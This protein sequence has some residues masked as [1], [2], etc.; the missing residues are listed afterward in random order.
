MLSLRL[1]SRRGLWQGPAALLAAAAAL[2]AALA[3]AA[4]ASAAAARQAGAGTGSGSVSI[5]SVSPQVA[6][7][8]GTVSV[9]GT[10]SNGTGHVLSGLQ[11]QLF[12][13]PLW[14]TTRDQMDA[15]LTGGTAAWEQA[16][17]PFVIAGGVAPGATA[18]WHASFKV[19]V[20]GMTQFGVYPLTAKLIGVSGGVLSSD[21][22]LLP[23]WPGKQAAGLAGPLQV[24][25]AWPL[26]DKPRRQV[27]T[28]LTGND[29]APSL[30]PG[31]RLAALLAAG[32]Q[33]PGADLTWVID[34]ALLADADAMTR[35]YQVGSTAN[36]TTGTAKEPASAAAARWLS[37]LRM[38][39]SQQQAVITPY[40][41]ADATALVHQGLTG[42]LG[43][44][45]ALGRVVAGDVLRRPLGY[46]VTA[47]AGGAADLSTLTALAAAEHVGTV[48]LNSS[49]MPP[50]P[51]QG[52]RPDNAVT[53]VRTG[54]G[55]TMSVLL[56]DD[57]LTRILAAGG[58]AAAAQGTQFA[59]EQRF[60]AE[61]AM[62]AAEAPASARAVVVAPPD[63]WSPTAALASA[64]LS[65][66]VSAP[67]LKPTTL[68]SL[69]GDG[70]D[71]TI[72]A[73]LPVSKQSPGELSGGY[74]S[75]VRA[76]GAS[77]SLYES[78]LYEAPAPYRQALDEALAATESS[79]WRGGAR[80]QG[81]ALA[82]GL[83]DYLA[84]AESKVKI[85]ASAQVTMGGASGT[86][87]V[88]IENGL[89][90]A[91][92]VSLNATVVGVPGKTSQL[93]IGRLHHPVTV[94][95]Q[96]PLTV[97]LPVSSAA[98][99]STEVRL[100]LSTADGR[101]LPFGSTSLNVQST[102]YGRAILLVI[103]A[104]LGVLVLTSA[105]RGVRR[106]LHGD[107]DARVGSGTGAWQAGADSHAGLGGHAHPG[108]GNSPG[109]VVTG[110]SGARN[111]TEAPDDLADARRW[112]DDA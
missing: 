109:N 12:T 89:H 14:F 72:R 101:M 23:F 10:V 39:I 90:Q 50:E 15:F 27:C 99:G 111:P 22:T 29:L 13:S 108:T 49:E 103:A 1:P 88:S 4:P 104:A 25:W 18:G 34:P 102:P 85:I 19:S 69:A 5:D 112:A 93:T 83:S 77:L 86:V 35:P 47:P 7:P 38:V 59:V 42:D 36:C 110:T 26:I 3:L 71:G 33:H 32:Q 48:V 92:R 51:S 43:A 65:E 94:Q 87:P 100:G 107:R 57:T 68:T 17:N 46:S 6:R 105:Y 56:A 66:T 79:A 95:P 20:A 28:A 75:A 78:M 98:I 24:A 16:G 55:T 58:P 84:D 9:T 96:Q 41:D 2:G 70:A 97:R 37:A 64:L 54:V 8:D 63:D 73:P 44:A 21:Q 82:N 53:S 74:L 67:W 60:L 11:V 40:A 76:V 81:L 106:W 52:W 31:G 61:T 80:W 45:Y 30:G 62:I 91:I